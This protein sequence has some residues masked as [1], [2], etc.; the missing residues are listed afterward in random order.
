MVIV[1]TTV[2][3]LAGPPGGLVRDPPPDPD[4]V[5]PSTRPAAA[6]PKAF[7]TAEGYGQDAVGGRGGR[8]LEVTTLADSGP[9]SLRAAVEAEGRRIVVFRVAGTI[10]LRERLLIDDPYLTVAGQS[11]PGDGIQIRNSPDSTSEAIRIET[12][13]VVVRFLRV[14]P[15]PTSAPT[16]CSGAVTIIN[17]AHDVI[18][19]HV[20]MSWGVD[21][22]VSSGNGA[23]DFTIQWSIIAQ[24]LDDSTH[25][26]GPHSFG[27]LVGSWSD[28][29]P[30]STHRNVAL[31]HNLF[32]HN[33]RRNPRVT[34]A[35][36]VVV[37]NNLVY[38]WR[39]AA[40]QV[41]DHSGVRFAVAILG[42]RFL[43]GPETATGPEV[44]VDQDLDPTPGFELYLDGNT[45]PNQPDGDQDQR[46]L[47][48][49]EAAGWV[50]D[51]PTFSW[52][53][54]SVTSAARSADQVLR[55]AGATVPA[56]DQVDRAIVQSVRQRSGQ[57]VDD[58]EDAGGWPS[59]AAGAPLP[60]RDHDGM[61][62]AWERRHGLDP[63]D[64]DD[65]R[66]RAPSGYTWVE[67]HLNEL[68]GD[69]SA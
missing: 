43:P 11:A 3:V 33:S 49:P 31:H 27:L 9:G 52:P 13:D 53:A 34:N 15:G 21:E 25:E 36:H 63:S 57:L 61:P 22:N 24:A 40:I 50:V 44:Q 46:A 68:A 39:E 14:R 55:N 7:P 38:N 66:R 48:P 20:S 2:L 58:P 41:G 6:P 59:L 5:A 64:P 8:L 62:D 12:H 19:D 1:V 4:P 67:V 16:C 65:G 42:N 35:G 26:E 18:L 45:G 17:G 37:A 30:P 32:A 56:R 23:H 51:D 10:T 54:I 69:G 29:H 28:D 60:D 47:L